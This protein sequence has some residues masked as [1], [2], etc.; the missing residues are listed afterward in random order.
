VAAALLLPFVPMAVGILGSALLATSLAFV[1]L[2]N[3]VFGPLAVGG[4][5]ALPVVSGLF[6]RFLGSWRVFRGSVV[7]VAV[8]AA[9]LFALGFAGNVNGDCLT[10]PEF[11][12]L[13]V[14]G[15]L[16]AIWVLVVAIVT[17]AI[18]RLVGSKRRFAAAAIVGGLITLPVLIAAALPYFLLGPLLL[19]AFSLPNCE[20]IHIL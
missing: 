8:A 10:V 3:I 4:I 5:F 6:I 17:A 7:I 11:I 12:Y 1:P 19:D 18:A 13:A 15:G 9:V 16:V 2:A 14:P 20:V